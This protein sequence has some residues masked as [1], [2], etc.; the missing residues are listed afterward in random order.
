M[1]FR[2]QYERVDLSKHHDKGW[3]KRI[4]DVIRRRCAGDPEFAGVWPGNQ[5]GSGAASLC[6]NL[7]A[8]LSVRTQTAYI[9]NVSKASGVRPKTIA[10]AIEDGKRLHPYQFERLAVALH[11]GIEYLADPF[12]AV[13]NPN[14]ATGAMQTMRLGSL[15]ED[16]KGVIVPDRNFV[17]GMY[18]ELNKGGLYPYA[19]YKLCIRVLLTAKRHPLRDTGKSAPVVYTLPIREAVQA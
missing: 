1:N 19:D 17:R 5:E 14:T 11:V 16:T 15:L 2:E 8:E 13:V 12:M 10:A 7:A 9:G 6:P 3:Y 4:V 18:E